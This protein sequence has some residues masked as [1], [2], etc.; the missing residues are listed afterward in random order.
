LPQDK[1]EEFR[2]TIGDRSFG[3]GDGAYNGIDAKSPATAFD[4][5]L[6]NKQFVSLIT[7]LY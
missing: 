2:L 1:Q 5:L 6:E 4:V 7:T 3:H